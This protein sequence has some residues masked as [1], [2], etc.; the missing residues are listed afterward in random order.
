LLGADVVVEA[1]RSRRLVADRLGREIA[2]AMLRE[3]A[4][5]D[6]WGASLAS[7]AAYGPLHAYELQRVLE[8]AL[9]SL[10]DAQPR[11]T[12]VLDLL[13]RLAQEAD[14][15]VSDEHAR[16]W[17][18]RLSARSKSGQLARAALSVTGDGGARSVEAAAAADE[19]ERDRALRWRSEA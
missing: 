3:T 17:L 10:G 13:R 11:M 4:V 14:A 7:V 9:G 6:R 2:R 18:E 8:G 12:K 16:P 1:I 15:R 5:A 19:A